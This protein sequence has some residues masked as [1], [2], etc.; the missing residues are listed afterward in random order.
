MTKQSDRRVSASRILE[1]FNV[2]EYIG[3]GVIRGS[4]RLARCPLDC[5]EAR[6]R[7]SPPICKGAIKGPETGNPDWDHISTSYVERSNLTMG[8]HM[9]R[10]TRLTKASSKKDRQPH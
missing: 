8:M 10:F 4:I 6:R 9:R 1:W 7:Y 2:A 5:Q 3:L